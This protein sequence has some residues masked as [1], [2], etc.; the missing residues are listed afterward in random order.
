MNVVTS[1]AECPR[2]LGPYVLLAPLARG[3]MGSVYIAADLEDS[4]PEK[5]CTIKTLRVDLDSNPEYQKRFVDEAVVATLLKHPNLCTTFDAGAVA[6]EYFLAM[7]L[8]EGLSLQQLI[9]LAQQQNRHLSIEQALWIVVSALRGLHAAHTTRQPSTGMSLD[10]VHR[11]VSPQNV[12]VDVFGNVKVIDFGLALS[13]LKA[14]QTEDAVVLGKLAYMS[15]EQARGE[16]VDT[17]ADQFAAGVILYEMLV[18]ERYYGDMPSRAIWTLAGAGT[19]RPRK[20]ERVPPGLKSVLA[21][22]LAPNAEKRFAS[23]QDFAHALEE[24]SGLQIGKQNS[25]EIGRI[26]E[27]CVPALRDRIESAK[28]VYRGLSEELRRAV[29]EAT[30]SMSLRLLGGVQ[31][32][33]L[34]SG[35]PNTTQNGAQNASAVD[36]QLEKTVVVPASGKTRRTQRK[37]A[38]RTVLWAIG[39]TLFAGAAALVILSGTRVTSD[40]GLAALTPAL[41]QQAAPASAMPTNLTEVATETE[42]VVAPQSGGTAHLEDI[43]TGDLVAV[44]AGP[45]SAKEETSDLATPGLPV[46]PLST[47]QTHPVSSQEPRQRSVR[48]ERS[49]SQRGAFR[50]RRWQKRV[51]KL[52]SC[53]NP[54]VASQKKILASTSPATALETKSAASI[55]S[56]LRMCERACRVNQ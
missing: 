6:G 38:K 46:G 56:L 11:D 16:S 32:H 51:Q 3:G 47:S 29:P 31:S 2:L 42:T 23:C 7:E 27:T 54:C 45:V 20:W 21:K 1:E 34:L 9:S 48:K 8:I 52:S 26:V 43:P 4:Q 15:P 30:Q 5:L 25:V 19:H 10:I 36:E 53:A 18:Q 33:H 24:S 50:L 39:G 49:S 22:S 17:R 37:E 41:P 55:L 35:G 40:N 44:D 13:A 12:M 14:T 28:T